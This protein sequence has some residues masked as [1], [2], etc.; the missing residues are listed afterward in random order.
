MSE[1]IAV[2]SPKGGVGKTFLASTLAVCLSNLGN[3]VLLVD[4]N[5]YASNLSL[6]LG[7]G[8]LPT[9]FNDVIKFNVPVEKAIYHF[10]DLL[11]ILPATTNIESEELTPD[12]KFLRDI[13]FKL[14]KGYE[15]IILDTEP[16]FTKNN[17]AVDTV[18]DKLL[19]IST[20]DIP[21]L[22]T[23]HKL[24]LMLRSRSRT[25]IQ[26][27]LNKVTHAYYELKDREVNELMGVNVVSIIPFDKHVLRAVSLR[28]EVDR[29]RAFSRVMTIA[30]G[31]ND[32]VKSKN[33]LNKLGIK[34]DKKK[35]KFLFFRF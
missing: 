17:L 33:N 6:Y 19:L 11:D 27:V 21:T 20:P 3:H 24:V 22:M 31:L 15:F 29:G 35:R 8:H 9:T 2:T 4:T 12:I 28:I 30:R 16:G 14:G 10:N 25:N 18:A 7:M 32:E 5:F 13:F 23:T 1:I 26:L 34:K